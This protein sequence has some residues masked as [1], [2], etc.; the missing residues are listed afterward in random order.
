[1]TIHTP[2]IP[3]TE[4]T[5]NDLPDPLASDAGNAT[6]GATTELNPRQ[7]A[8][9]RALVA[10]PGS[11]ATTIGAAADMSRVAAGKILNQLEADGRARR[12]PG[13]QD[14]QTKG[15]TP[16]QW[17]A[18]D[19]PTTATDGAD[20]PDA[21][22]TA[23]AGDPDPVTPET[24]ADSPEPVNATDDTTIKLD[25][26]Q[27]GV[28][29]ALYA[30]PGWPAAPLS[31][32]S[33]LTQKATTEVLHQLEAAGLVSRPVGEGED[34][35]IDEWYLVSDEH[36]MALLNEDRDAPAEEA[37]PTN[38][39]ESEVPDEPLEIQGETDDALTPTTP[40]VSPAMDF[41]EE[42]ASESDAEPEDPERAQARRELLELADLILGAAAAMEADGDA[43]L[44]LG[45][46]EM[47]MA[48]APQAHRNARAVLTGTTPTRSA[49]GRTTPARSAGSGATARPSGL[50][51][52]VLNH[53]A[54]HPG[55]DFTPYE[56]G[57]VLDSSSGAVA[58]ALDRLVSLGQAEL[59]CERPRR[60]SLSEVPS[61]DA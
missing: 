52:R 3:A 41:G 55:K 1:M 5:P 46:L 28:L 33:G 15:R 48:K 2:E 26:R 19:A 27:E 49:T 39:P 11:S 24:P 20:L 25:A 14:G 10:N 16:D 38:P 60:F 17:Y 18:I 32:L 53:L 37:R 54:E 9:W 34:Q 40:D 31:V 57:R 58:N 50:R 47:A 30:N 35:N 59:T 22:E 43:V 44:A 61:A 13:G 21:A 36:V 29:A 23:L 56:I 12:T 7:E 42:S 45:R 51:D 6:D 8:V 4:S